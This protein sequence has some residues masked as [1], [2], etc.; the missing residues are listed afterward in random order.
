[1][2]TAHA[3][4]KPATGN[5]HC[6]TGAVA[7]LCP[8]CGFCCTGVLF[9]DVELQPGDDAP[10]LQALGMKLLAKGRKR[11][12]GQPCACHDG[13]LCRIYA[14]RPERCR[15]FA[16]RLLQRVRAGQ[17]T[18]VAA[19]RR[20]RAAVRAAEA[21]RRL[22]RTL[23]ETDETVP[24]SRRVARVL[25]QPLDFARDDRRI[26]RRSKLLGAV[27]RLAKRLARDFLP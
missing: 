27:D 20:I 19:G 1:M 3:R 17:L 14:E 9:A 10:R 25:A 2:T 18:P 24:L 8:A 6:E 21:V 4:S 11:C 22:V 16:C 23:G 12:F 5:A 13:R 15:T 26:E 7:A